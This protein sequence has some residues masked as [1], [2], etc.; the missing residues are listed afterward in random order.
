MNDTRKSILQYLYDHRSERAIFTNEISQALGIDNTTSIREAEYLVG[1]QLA[2][3][4]NTRV[5]SGDF[6]LTISSDGID[7]IEGNTDQSGNP[8]TNISFNVGRDMNIGSSVDNSTTNSTVRPNKDLSWWLKYLVLPVIVG[9][10][11]LL[12]GAYVFGVG[13]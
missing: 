10:T 8:T 6:N 9:L 11:V 1:K 3:K 2:N 7:L 4:G 5:M 12:T 13:K